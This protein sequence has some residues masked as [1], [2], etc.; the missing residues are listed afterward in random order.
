MTDRMRSSSC[1]TPFRPSLV[2]SALAAALQA[3]SAWAVEPFV[4]KDIRVE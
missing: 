4:L 3:G 1:S 2:S